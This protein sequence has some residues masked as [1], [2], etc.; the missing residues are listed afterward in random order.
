MRTPRRGKGYCS[1]TAAVGSRRGPGSHSGERLADLVLAELPEGHAPLAWKIP[2]KRRENQGEQHRLCRQFQLGREG[3]GAELPGGPPSSPSR[4]AALDVRLSVNTAR[5]VRTE[6]SDPARHNGGRS[7]GPQGSRLDRAQGKGLWLQL[8]PSPAILA[9]AEGAMGRRPA[10][11]FLPWG[12]ESLPLSA[13]SSHVS[14]LAQSRLLENPFP[15][16][17]EVEVEWTGP[18]VNPSWA[19]R[20]P[21]AWTPLSWGPHPTYLMSL[22]L[23]CFPKS[24]GQ[25]T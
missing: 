2:P 7:Q 23:E 13:V 21:R 20:C 6:Q 22:R 15:Q 3:L 14:P 8:R 12:P 24:L 11:H 17:V 19:G 4:A 18:G 9:V 10:P 1:M 5:T 16:R 25:V